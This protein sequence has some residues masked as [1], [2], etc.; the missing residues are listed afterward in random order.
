[1]PDPIFLPTVWSELR[2]LLALGYRG[3]VMLWAE[4]GKFIDFSLDNRVQSLR[5][6]ASAPAPLP[7]VAETACR[8]Q[9]E[10]PPEAPA[11]E[12]ARHS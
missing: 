3:P 11:E 5:T 4:D 1:M 2:R 12:E 10:L 6:G 7:A 8:Q 9:G